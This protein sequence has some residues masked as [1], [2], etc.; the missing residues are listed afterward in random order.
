MVEHVST[1][2]I[3]QFLDGL[4]KN[5]YFAGLSH[6]EQHQ[7]LE[8]CIQYGEIKAKMLG[9]AIGQ[10]DEASLRKWCAEQKIKVESVSTKYD[11]PYISEYIGRKRLINL[12]PRRINEMQESL[13][14]VCPEYFETCSLIEMCL[15]HEMFHHIEH[16][17]YGVTG[18]IIRVRSGLMPFLHS[19]DEGSEIAAHTFVSALLELPFSTYTFAEQLKELWQKE[20][21]G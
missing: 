14:K 15:A 6:E 7:L 20:S 1:H 18:R 3:P 21:N 8:K 11:L 17:E 16:E 12:Y 4:R 19:V 5:K 10:V 2:M 13:S 9:D